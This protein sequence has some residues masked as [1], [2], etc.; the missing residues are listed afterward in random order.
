[1]NGKKNVKKNVQRLENEDLPTNNFSTSAQQL[2]IQ[3]SNSMKK[4]TA[5][6]RKLLQE[7]KKT[8]SLSSQLFDIGIGTLLGDASLQTQDGGKT[9]RLKYSQS[10]K[11]HR[12]YLFHLHQVWS[13]WVLSP[14]F[15]NQEREML[16]FQTISHS[17]FIKLARIFVFNEKNILCSKSIKSQFVEFYVTPRVLA[18]WFMDDGGKA[19]YNKDYPRRG[20]VFN[21][22]GFTKH[23]V[24]VLCQGLYKCYN[25][26]C[27]SKLNKKGHVIVISAKTSQVLIDLMRPYILPSMLEKLPKF[28]LMT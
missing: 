28:K 6:Q 5:N 7:Y 13:D 15:H 12:D 14:P 26:E 17:E 3:F 24:D 4:P 8:L 25:I 2:K 9:F 16:S 23:H 18:Y 10:E 11:K 22:Q 19:C 21:T 1:M 20:L 27:W